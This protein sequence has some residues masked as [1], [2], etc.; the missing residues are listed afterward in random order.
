MRRPASHRALPFLAAA[1]AAHLLGACA[2]ETGGSREFA[3]P[4]GSY[5]AAFDATSDLLRE[6][7]FELERIDAA[8]GVITTKAH[9]SPG[10]LEPW[11]PTQTGLDQEWEDALNMQ[12]RE[13][14][15]TF[16][17]ADQEPAAADAALTSG[18][19]PIDLRQA[20]GDLVGS[21][22]VTIFRQQR[23]GRRLDSEWVGGS[24]VYQDPDL[25]ARAGA[26]Y[27]VPLRRDERLEARLADR[28]SDEL[29]PAETPPQ[30]SE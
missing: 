17:P 20:G 9:F 26:R 29:P 25:N 1:S 13:V 3:V 23:A 16:A 12:A 21:V 27:L 14:R 18:E 22:W 8:S 6:M 11:D 19:A 15:V 24:T 28:I 30:Q 10:L 7:H 5:E 2:A 4:A